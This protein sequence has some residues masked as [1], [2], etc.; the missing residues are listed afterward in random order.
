[1]EAIQFNIFGV[2]S[3]FG[4]I[5]GFILAIIFAFH[6][7]FTKRA[8]WFLSLL[9]LTLS[10]ASFW[11][12]MEETPLYRNYPILEL[13]PLVWAGLVAPLTYFFI[14]FLTN[15]AYKIKNWEYLLFLSFI[16][17][18][19]VRFYFLA[20]F[21]TGNFDI[22]RDR[23][24]YY[25]IRKIIEIIDS[26]IGIAVLVNAIQTL[27]KYELQLLGNYS[28]ISDKSLRWLHRLLIGGGVLCLIWLNSAFA[29]FYT[30][31]DINYGRS[32]WM[33]ISVL[34]YWIGY[35][36]L[37]Q[38][39]L[40][41]NESISEI[42]EPPEKVSKLS[43]KTEEHYQNLLIAIEE[44]ELFRNPNLNMTL[45]AKEVGLSKGYLSQI[46]NQKEEKNF[47][48]LINAYRVKDVK[49]KMNDPNFSHYSIFGIAL[50]AGF[51]SKSTFNSVFKKMTGLTPTQFRKSSK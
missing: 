40:F 19:L 41:M 42:V 7:S 18:T 12:A 20:K 27:K 16:I 37:I 29:F 49:L 25:A 3:L 24:T 50:E 5:Q 11:G 9:L 48:E 30:A 26:V 14:K 28:D 15:P 46:I 32:L 4:A 39:E 34:I 21:Q 38:R 36:M 6:S 31:V 51:K 22:E 10:L 17:D 1:M 23:Y 2:F 33:G 45:L 8:N 44:K 43:D 35:G 13:L 47:F